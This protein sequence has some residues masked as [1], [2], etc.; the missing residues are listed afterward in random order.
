MLSRFIDSSTIRGKIVNPAATNMNF[1]NFSFTPVRI[2]QKKVKA[3]NTESQMIY[4]HLRYND[5]V[6]D[7]IN[8]EELSNAPILPSEETENPFQTFS[9]NSP[10]RA[11]RIYAPSAGANIGK[12][13]RIATTKDN[14]RYA[15]K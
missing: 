5:S 15:M 8:V 12:A 4:D 14:T 9:N 6:Y 3:T 11:P 1:A 10:P 7:S 13:I 2:N